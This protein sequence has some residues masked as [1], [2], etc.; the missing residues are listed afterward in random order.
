[1]NIAEET[2]PLR[3]YG[4]SPYYAAT[5]TKIF[6]C[7]RSTGPYG[8]ASARTQRPPT[9][10]LYTVFHGIGSRLEP[11]QFSGPQTSTG[12]LL[13]TLLRIAASKLTFQLFLA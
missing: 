2:W 7:A 1:M 10:S 11:R 9:K 4:F 13:R 12:D 8:P 6:V 5:I 3:R